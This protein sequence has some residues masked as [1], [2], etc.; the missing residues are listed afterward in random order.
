MIFSERRVA[1][2]AAYFLSK[3]DGRKMHL[4][5]LMKLLYLADRQSLKDFHSNISGD[6]MMSMDHGPVLSRTYNYMTGSMQSTEGGWDSWISDRENHQLSLKREDIERQSLD[7]LSDAGL[8]ILDKVWKQF[9][10]RDEWELRDY[11]HEY[12]KEWKDPKGTSFPISYEDIF[13]ALNHPQDQAK[14]LAR[15]CEEEDNTARSF[16]NQ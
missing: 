11:T 10:E 15:I 3:E 8:S 5:K 4:I 7:E 2:M 12:C 13:L 1:Q 14:E 6:C 9:G 16:V